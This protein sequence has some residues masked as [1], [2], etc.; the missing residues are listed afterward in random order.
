MDR[1][2][3]VLEYR[4]AETKEASPPQWGFRFKGA[5]GQILME[6]A[7]AFDSPAKAEEGFVAMIKLIATNQYTIAGAGL[8]GAA[9]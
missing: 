3:A 5:D 2:N 8:P 4:I 7:R 9:G 1:R 6:S